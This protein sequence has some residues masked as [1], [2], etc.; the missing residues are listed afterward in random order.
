MFRP[1]F[2]RAGACVCLLFLVSS[3]FALNIDSYQIAAEK[4]DD[5]VHLALFIY[6]SNN[7]SKPVDSVLLSIPPDSTVLSVSDFYGSLGY[8]KS[9]SSLKISFPNPIVQDARRLILV[10]LSSSSVLSSK[11]DF[12]EY[13]L[14]FDPPRD[15][16]E[17]EH[18]FKL[19]GSDKGSVQFVSPQA[20]VF[21]KD[22]SV[23]VRWALPL[24]AG[25]PQ[26][27]IVRF[28]DSRFDPVPFLFVIF[29]FILAFF[30]YRLSGRYLSSIKKSKLID[31]LK[32]LNER[33]RVVVEEVVKKNGVSQSEL[34][35]KFGYTKASMS[36]IVSKLVFREILIKRKHGKSNLLYPGKRLS[37]G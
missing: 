22:N 35:W 29:L 8:G 18:T 16:P 26:P 13:M 34:Q 20:E 21:S 11:G 10:E 31:S 3:S 5:A 24:K 14:I 36:K 33:E 25:V 2:F 15:I 7:E 23:L 19:P 37:D 28:S 32:I 27:F 17:F 4:A 12:S 6:V 30:A 1:S 9:G